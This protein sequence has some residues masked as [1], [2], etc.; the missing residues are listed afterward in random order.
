[1]KKSV[2]LDTTIILDFFLDRTPFSDDAAQIF[3]L[4]A[5]KEIKAYV[6]VLTISNC[7]YILRKLAGHAKVIRK[8]EL[9]LTI[10]SV[11]KMDKHTVLDGLESKFKDFEDALQYFSA[12]SYPSIDVIITRNTKDFKHSEIAIMT[13]EIFLKSLA[14][15]KA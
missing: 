11:S 8:L 12:S 1:M 6:S 14:L 4:A 5:D 13:P 3:G 9:L 10:V 7:Y 2:F 15:S